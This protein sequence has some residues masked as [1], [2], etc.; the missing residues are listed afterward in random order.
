M[1]SDRLIV[2]VGYR[3][4]HADSVSLTR[5]TNRT[6]TLKD[7]APSYKAGAVYRPIKGLALFYNYADTF[8]LI[9]G[10]TYFGEPYKPEVG[11]THEYGAKLDLFDGKWTG[12]VSFATTR[13]T[14]VPEIA[15]VDP[16]RGIT[17]S[18]QT[19]WVQSRGLEADVAFKPIPDV[20]MMVG[21]GNTNSLTDRGVAQRNVPIGGNFKTLGKLSLGRITSLKGLSIGAGYIHTPRRAGDAASTFFLPPYEKYNAFVVLE[22]GRWRWQVN[23]DNL[24]NSTLAGVSS[25]NNLYVYAARPRSFLGSVEYKW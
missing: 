25:V 19:G 12:T 8:I 11:L 10:S 22:R 17:G 18:I 20:T 24:K 6:T 5:V 13:L 3:R 2:Q 23:A 21:Y 16:V 9:S 4:D 7:G 15:I 1:F 14:N